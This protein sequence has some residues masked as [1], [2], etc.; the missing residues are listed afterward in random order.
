[1]SIMEDSKKVEL[2]EVV[3]R[4]KN[5][6][7]IYPGTVALEQGNLEIKRGEVHGIV[8]KNG[9]G[10]S[11]LMGIIAGIVTPTTGEIEVDGKNFTI[12]SRIGSKK[13][14]IAI[15]P[16]EP[17]VI[18]DLTVAENLFT[19]DYPC[20]G[21]FVDWQKLYKAAKEI[22]KSSGLNIDVEIKMGDLSILLRKE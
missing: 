22:L 13:E 15:V 21:K 1:M 7:K 6:S 14:K 11:T 12:L 10:K 4:L 18:N 5:I 16:Q 3:L 9:A 17:Q 20:R 8:G 2:D 19:P